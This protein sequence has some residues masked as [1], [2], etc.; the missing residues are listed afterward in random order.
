M[1]KPAPQSLK[2][3]NVE[4]YSCVTLSD[5]TA[6]C[7][8]ALCPKVSAH[9][10]SSCIVLRTSALGRTLPSAEAA[11]APVKRVRKERNQKLEHCINELNRKTAE[12]REILALHC[13]DF[14]LHN[15]EDQELLFAPDSPQC[16]LSSAEEHRYQTAYDQYDD[17]VQ[18]LRERQREQHCDKQDI[19]STILNWDAL[20]NRDNLRQCRKTNELPINTSTSSLQPEDPRWPKVPSCVVC[21]RVADMVFSCGHQCVCLS[22]Y[23]QMLEGTSRSLVRTCPLCKR[24]V[25]SVIKVF[26]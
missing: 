7:K 18:S 15:Y 3:A 2:K 17:A 16:Q 1:L 11:P 8:G 12:I 10:P 14:E 25:T 22:C 20:P 19:S 26:N 13:D 4:Q 9:K 6:L 21:N 5:R 23:C 24:A